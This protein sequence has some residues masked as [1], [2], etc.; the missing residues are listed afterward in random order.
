MELLYTL[1]SYWPC[2]VFGASLGIASEISGANDDDLLEGKFEW[3]WIFFL[4]ASA[5]VAAMCVLLGVVI[6]LPQLDQV[7]SA[8]VAIGLLVSVISFFMA[9]VPLNLIFRSSLF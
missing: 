1:L 9:W 2:A 6:G 3:V 4:V 8:T 5:T 7:T